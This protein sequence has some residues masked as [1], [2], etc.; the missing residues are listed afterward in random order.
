MANTTGS[1]GTCS[2]SPDNCN[3]KQ[4]I[5]VSNLIY[6]TGLA[7]RLDPEDGCSRFS[8]GLVIGGFLVNVFRY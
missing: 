5:Q 6:S 2:S 1:A 4:H 3:I 8:I 7:K